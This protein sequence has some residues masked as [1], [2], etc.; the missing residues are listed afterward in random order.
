M[1]PFRSFH[2]RRHDLF[3]SLFLLLC[4]DS[5]PPPSHHHHTLCS[6]HHLNSMFPFHLILFVTSKSLTSR[7]K[8]T[9]FLIVLITR[10][11]AHSKASI[12]HNDSRLI[13]ETHALFQSFRSDI[14][15]LFL[16]LSEIVISLYYHILH[17]FI[18]FPRGW[19][20]LN[21]SIVVLFV[22]HVI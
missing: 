11:R 20:H 6:L 16:I 10:S 2:F 9:H 21:T 1:F 12:K 15:H 13:S 7:E 19:V 8:P 18:P 14:S 4:L 3:S 5:F 17:V 22:I